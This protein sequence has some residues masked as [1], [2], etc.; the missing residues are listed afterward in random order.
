MMIMKNTRYSVGGLMSFAFVLI[1]SSN[2]KA[3]NIASSA[4]SA[5]SYAT[6][7]KYE[8]ARPLSIGD[9]VPDLLFT[10]VINH[11]GKAIRLSDFK[12]KMIILDFWATW[13]SACIKN[14]PKMDSLQ[15]KFHDQLQILLVN[16]LHTKDTKEKVNTFF[17]KWGKRHGNLNLPVIIKDSIT[18]VLFPHKE[19]PHYV[20]IK[21]GIVTAITDALEIN[22]ENVEGVIKGSITKLKEKR[23]NMDFDFQKPLFIN[24][25]GG[26]GENIK[27]RSL[28]TAHNEQ[29]PTMSGITVDENYLKSAD[30]RLY[31]RIFCFNLPIIELYKMAIPE[32]M[33]YPINRMIF[34]VK[35]KSKYYNMDVWA[36]DWKHAN[37]YV[38]ELIVPPTKLEN[39]RSQMLDNLN[40]FFNLSA[41]IETRSVKCLALLKTG[42]E[43]PISSSKEEPENSLYETD[44][45]P[46]H[47]QNQQLSV[48][49]HKMN[50]LFEMPVIDETNFS[51]KVNMQLPADLSDLK[52][53]KTAL[54]KYGFDLIEREQQLKMFMLAELK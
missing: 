7:I 33:D 43:I 21:N 32:I 36:D 38:Y 8:D 44:G 49:V 50:D 24:G 3:Q 6:P 9:K 19:I 41:S 31:T 16:T 14:F 28:I 5:S 17:D 48:L 4:I 13:C 12:N 52:K 23:D 54:N 30:K 26:A 2:L 45:K 53:L 22:S 18:E 1:L 11:S 51:G 46:K 39:I 20:W 10:E 35:D 37:T 34:Q 25:N 47:I 27:Y 15:G 42:K 40:K 29:L